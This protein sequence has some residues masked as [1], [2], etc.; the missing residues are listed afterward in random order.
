MKC[1]NKCVEHVLR[2]QQLSKIRCAI[3][4]TEENSEQLF[5][6]VTRLWHVTN[7]ECT[8]NHWKLKNSLN[9]L[10]PSSDL[11]GRDPVIFQKK[12]DIRGTLEDLEVLQTRFSTPS[13]P[14]IKNTFKYKI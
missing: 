3:K 1:R 14:M 12:H 6:A 11:C 2:L 10:S 7:D 9:L 4:E 13:T 8:N 5:Q